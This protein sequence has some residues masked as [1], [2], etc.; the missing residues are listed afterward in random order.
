MEY[1]DEEEEDDEEEEEEREE[2]TCVETDFVF[3]DFVRRFANMKVVKAMAILLQGFETNSIE[4]N[5]YIVKMLHRIAWDCKMSAMI[6]QASIFRIFQKILNS[7][8]S[9]HKELQKFAIFI[10]RRFTETAQ[11]NHKAY[12][13]LLFWK[14]TL[15]ANEMVEGYDTEPANK[16][17]SRAVW[18]EEEEDE[19]RTLFMEHQTNKYP[20]DLIDWLL[21]NLINKDRTSRG[22]MKKLREMCLI[23]NSKAVR[24]EIQKRLPKE[25]SEEEV[26]QLTE[27]WEHVREQ[28]DPVDLIYDELRIKRPKSKIKEKLL[29]LGLA[30]DRKELR[31]K[32]TKKS[33]AE[34]KSS[35]EIVS[36]NE[37][38]SDS[39]DSDSD[40]STSSRDVPSTSRKQQKKGKQKKATFIYSDFQLSGLLKDVINNGMQ[41]ALKWITE[42]LEESLDNRDEESDEGIALVPLTGET[43]A[44]MDSPS[45]QRLIRAM[46]IEPPD[47]EQNF[48]RIPANMLPA[49]IKKRCNLI[50]AALRGEFVTEEPKKTAIDSDSEDEDVFEKLR[51]SYKK[52]NEIEEPEKPKLNTERI[53]LVSDSTDSEMK[54]TKVST[55]NSKKVETERIQISSDSSD[56]ENESTKI[57]NVD[58][59][60]ETTN[61]EQVQV[62]DSSDSKIETTKISTLNSKKEKTTNR[63]SKLKRIQ[64][65]SDS[66]DSEI[67]STTKITNLN[68]KNDE[69][70][71]TKMGRIQLVSDSSDSE[72]ENTKISTS[73]ELKR[74][75][76]LNSDIDTP[77]TK[78]RRVLQSDE[79]EEDPESGKIQKIKQTRIIVSDDED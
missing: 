78:K 72:I 45:F 21:E 71:K 56:S 57:S 13:E 14:T 28:D 26:A 19:L 48:W 24:N 10:I 34:P 8:T 36:R 66:S 63:N 69:S 25:W 40:G 53:Q 1:N 77:L 12:M 6:F 49:S 70:T 32:R 37:S 46:G 27:I 39:D 4:V 42:S 79:E 74:D 22:V 59:K 75:R 33:N 5:H 67:E 55:L 29:E 2:R 11:K 62:S 68:S 61:T 65:I 30:K 73:E 38:G 16:K 47:Q 50:E 58:L 76:S 52:N 41:E 18:S 23:V 60:D 44:A 3:I 17:V 54:S 31:K 20:Q 35:W 43:S 64:S 51:Q 15:Q 7:K 9:Q